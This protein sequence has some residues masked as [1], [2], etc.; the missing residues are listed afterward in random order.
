MAD[1]AETPPAPAAHTVTLP[2]TFSNSFW[3]TDY[4]QGITSL[5]QAL[6]R[7]IVESDELVSHVQERADLERRIA[8]GLLPPALRADGFAGD[9]GASLRMGF[10]AV[11][12][13]AV[14]EAKARQALAEDLT[15]NI[16][17]P[18]RSWSHS[19][20]SRISTSHTSLSTSLTAWEKQKSLVERIKTAYDDACRHADSVEDELNF[21][22]ARVEAEA[23]RERVRER[24][25]TLSGGSVGSR[26]RGEAELPP[27]PEE[28]DALEARVRKQEEKK[29]TRDDDEQS[30]DGL[31]PLDDDDGLLPH[32]GATGGSVIGA[33]GRAFSVRRPAA[34]ASLRPSGAASPGEKDKSGEEEK[35]GEA[36]H[37]AVEQAR[38]RIKALAES[39]ELKKGVEWSKTK[40]TSLLSRVQTQVAPLA[41]GGTGEERWIRAKKVADEAEEKYKREVEILDGLRLTLESHLSS[42][43]PYLQRCETDRLRA[44]ASV[45]KSYHSAI[46]ALPQKVLDSL[47]RV[48]SALEL[49][50]VEKDVRGV[51]ERGRTGSFTPRPTLYTSHYAEPPLTTF[52]IDLRKFDETNPA[53]KDEDDPANV[54]PPVLRFL[55]RWI[56]QQGEGVEEGERRK[57]WLYEIPLSAQHR[58][59]QLLNSPSTLSLPFD[60]LSALL[61]R[62]HPDSGEAI[63][64]P[65]ACSTVKLWLLELEVPV[66]TW[67][68]Y[69]EFRTLFPAR[70]GGEKE[71]VSTEE[72]A[73]IVGKLPRVHYEVL[74]LLISHLS[75]LISST[76][77]ASAIESD[78]IFLQ[79]LSLSLSRPLMRP[80]TETAL[81]LDARFPA[82]TIATLI[83][84]SDAIFPA[85]EE[86]AK[87]EREER[88]KPRRQR[89]KPIDVRPTRGNLGIGARESVDLGRAGQV[90]QQV[91]A[92]GAPPPPLPT[93]EGAEPTPSTGAGSSP[94]RQQ[95]LLGV[96]TSVPS[97]GGGSFAASPMSATVEEFPSIPAPAPA[98]APAPV[99]AAADVVGPPA[100]SAPPAEE[101]QQEKE[102][103]A[104]AP[105]P[106]AITSPSS[107]P[108]AMA[109]PSPTSAAD[110]S[111]SPPQPTEAPFV[112]PT[113]AP[114]EAPFVPPSS[115][116]SSSSSS[117]AGD[118]PLSTSSSLK[119]ATGAGRLRGARAPRPP[120]Q[121]M[122]RIRAFEGGAAEGDKAGAGSKRESWT[123]TRGQAPVEA[124]EE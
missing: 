118:A 70:V 13:S 31:P 1:T 84:H 32:S 17:H 76:P 52:G 7:G 50:R 117:S 109:V 83:K 108:P 49:V 86:A 98:P 69:E 45:L 110:D 111:A 20:A 74:K 3:S 12:T 61:L 68:R 14:G 101:P 23:E 51:V 67:E 120:S 15:R 93:R 115:S 88:Y 8:D 10:E 56:E 113:A 124:D 16:V 37:K 43:L 78:D 96:D 24:E 106:E 81:T 122:D 18:F 123:T 62:P 95:S 48:G 26:G 4:R 72:V 6:D 54:V 80:K 39:E 47:A 85:A 99:P 11:L 53:K 33:L 2:L 75:R 89:T 94:L 105:A 21:S 57:S 121:V 114:S 28:V 112:P 97:G 66:V 77:S 87:K 92:G 30:E 40:F 107:P 119:R 58:L 65:V 42:H 41:G 104:P 25:R 59:R 79:K 34:A 64:L 116:S 29:G 44:A 60:S 9:E 71:D 36:G 5:F 90:L 22:R 82:Q 27:R 55:L 46:S 35:E 103:P 19:H 63:D 38:E 102:A 100:P 73:K 91:R